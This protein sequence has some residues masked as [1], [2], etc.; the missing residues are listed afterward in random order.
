METPGACNKAY[1]F[2]PI[3]L[4]PTAIIMK[5]HKIFQ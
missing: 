1:F 4:F 5:T 3:A 2:H